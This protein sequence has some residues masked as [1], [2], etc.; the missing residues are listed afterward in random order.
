M[1]CRYP[2]GKIVH[3]DNPKN[4]VDKGRLKVNSDLKYETFDLSPFNELPIKIRWR[5][6]ISENDITIFSCVSDST[7]A[8]KF[9]F[10]ENPLDEL[11]EMFYGALASMQE[12]F[13]NEIKGTIL[14]GQSNL[15]P[16]K[17]QITTASLGII[18][19]ARNE[20]IL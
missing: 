14:E 19:I 7:C 16:D 4:L 9:E 15:S 6:R 3:F 11:Q 13:E 20:K 12:R 8:V 5:F 1:E 10:G 2:T 17:E 18:R